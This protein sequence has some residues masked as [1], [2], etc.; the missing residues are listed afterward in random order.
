MIQERAHPRSR[1][2][3][4]GTTVPPMVTV[5][6]SPLTRGK[7]LGL[8]QHHQAGGLIPAHA[9]KTRSTLCST[10]GRRAHPRSRGENLVEKPNVVA[11]LGSSPLTRGKRR[12]GRHGLFAR[13][14]IPAHAGKTRSDHGRRNRSRAH[15]RS[16]GENR[17]RRGEP[18]DQGGSS[19]LTR[20]KH[21]CADAVAWDQG[22]I[23]AHAGKT[24]SA[25]GCST[26]EWAHPRSRGE[27]T[28][29]TSGATMS[30]GS[31]PLTRGKRALAEAGGDE[32]RL[33]PAH[34]GKTA[35]YMCSR[36][37]KEAHPRS[38]GENG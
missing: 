3:N 27:N 18:V 6:S 29:V 12:E 28:A 38:R 21:L 24:A 23:P 10:T 30:V 11:G 2:E 32:L 13:G 16:R 4:A 35:G 36:Y 31:S 9:G 7:H 25:R 34:A 1:G 19:P 22:L 15:P 33:I 26:D 5:G 14:L 20:G 8:R 37:R 17:D